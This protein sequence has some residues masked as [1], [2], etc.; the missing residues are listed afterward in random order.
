MKVKLILLQILPICLLMNIALGQQKISKKILFQLSEVEIQNKS[1]IQIS[2]KREMIIKEVDGDE[3]NYYLVSID[4][5]SQKVLIFIANENQE[6]SV[7][8]SP[9]GEFVYYTLIENG[10]KILG[11]YDR[12]KDKKLF[13]KDET[14]N[15]VSSWSAVSSSSGKI[16]YQVRE[17]GVLPKVFMAQPDGSELRFITEGM[18][19][20]WAPNGKW[21]AV[22]CPENVNDFKNIYKNKKRGE[23][24][25]VLRW[26]YWIYSSDGNPIISFEEYSPTAIFSWSPNSKYVLFK[27]MYEIDFTILELDGSS[28]EIRIVN[29]H[30]ISLQKENKIGLSIPIWSPDSRKLSYTISYLDNTGHYY[31]K[32]EIWVSSIDGKNKIKI[33]ESDNTEEEIFTWSNDGKI[34]IKQKNKLNK[35]ISIIE[36]T[37]NDLWNSYE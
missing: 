21:F 29:H 24:S 12:E 19:E 22:K 9:Y 7:S 15:I 3:Y 18:G 33:L 2:P 28:K 35:D 30:M 32:N 36:I 1:V 34:I 17:E 13:I 26:F 10:K 25:K 31:I 11:I 8:F 27:K 20:Q 6:P 37:F 4:N 16:I 23:I 5:P 14:K